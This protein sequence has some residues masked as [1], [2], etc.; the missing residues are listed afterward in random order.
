MALRTDTLSMT[1]AAFT[2]RQAASADRT[3][4]DELAQLDSRRLTDDRYTVAEIDG[5][6][7]AA[8]SNTTG[9]AIADPFRRTAE[10]VELL[11][12]HAG[13][14]TVKQ[15]RRQLT[16]RRHRRPAFA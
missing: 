10:I 1:S 16:L 11:R 15:T 5:R 8:I 13:Q 2:L 7:V 14:V 12:A 9:D 3:A 4:L 6:I